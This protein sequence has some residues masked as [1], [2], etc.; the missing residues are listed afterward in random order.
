MNIYN[1][2]SYKIPYSLLQSC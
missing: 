1:P 2:S